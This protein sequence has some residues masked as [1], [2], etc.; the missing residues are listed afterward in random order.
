M[1]KTITSLIF[2]FLLIIITIPQVLANTQALGY[3]ATVPATGE[4]TT[5]YSLQ[6]NKNYKWVMNYLHSYSGSA[7]V[8]SYYY[9]KYNSGSVALS[10]SDIQLSSTGGGV[11]RATNVSTLPSGWTINAQR[12]CTGSGI[13]DNYCA[14]QGSSYVLK[15]DNKNL[16]NSFTVN[17]QLTFTD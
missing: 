14:I 10:G 15:V 12:T 8:H 16:L 13:S 5:S 7:V 4:Y 2:T 17:G 3:N 11:W 1:K 6:A 9:I